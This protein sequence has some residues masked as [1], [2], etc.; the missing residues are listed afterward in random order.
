MQ[1][2]NQTTDYLYALRNRGS[3]YGIERM[4]RLVDAL[5]HPEHQFPVIHVAGTNG[6]GSVCAM[7]EALYRSNGYKTGLFT[8]PHLVHLGERAQVNRMILDEPGI[9]RYVEELRPV[10]AKLGEEDDELHPTFFE[11]VAAMAFLRFASEQ[12]GIAMIETGLGG[13]LD[14]TN[15][16][17][18]ELSIITSI[19]FDHMEMLGDTLTKIATEKAGIIKPGKPVLIGRLPEEAEL[20]IRS[21]AEER[22]CPLYSVRDRFCEDE[23]PETNLAGQ[24]QRWNAGLAVYA[25]ELLAERFPARSTR[26]LQEVDWAGRWQKLV[27]ADQTLILDATHNPEGAAALAENLKELTAANG[28]K[29]I[30]VAGTLGEERGR[31]LMKSV[32]PYAREL[33]LVVPKQDRA[34]PT[35][36]L[37]NCLPKVRDY[38]VV[39]STLDQLFTAPSV[40]APLADAGL[41]E[42]QHSALRPASASVSGKLRRDKSG[43]STIG[44]PGDTIV[45]TGSIYLIGEVLERLEGKA[46]NGSGLQDKV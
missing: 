4:V 14:A 8:S 32:A 9:V 46:Q 29:P 38:K 13:R 30:I 5:G 27:L 37:E 36:F 21:V 18:P 43:A 33:Y 35:V 10:A 25:T 6:K 12:V 40:E 31:S 1:T 41:I 22:G 3:K 44:Q 2:Y 7:L 15:V 11:F 16:V 34:T 28:Q 39:H 17:D 42:P 23:L 24:F 45:V 26:G 20:A 19:S